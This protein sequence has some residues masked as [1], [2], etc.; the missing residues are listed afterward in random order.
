[1]NYVQKFPVAICGVALGF[2]ALGNL[3]QTSYKGLYLACGIISIFLLAIYTLKFIVS[4]KVVLREL[5]DPIG[6][7]VAATFPMAVMLISVYMKADIG[8]A[9]QLFWFVGIALHILCIALFTS[10][11]VT[12]F[13]WENVHASWFVARLYLC[14]SNKSLYCRIYSIYYAKVCT[15]SFGYAGN[16]FNYLCGFFCVVHQVSYKT[17]LSQPCR[18]YFSFCN[19]C[20]CTYA[21]VGIP[22]R[23]RPASPMARWN[24][25]C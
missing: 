25:H 10:R 6:L 21:D 15:V 11:Y 3:F 8:D 22:G 7:S 24:R 23:T 13:N 18:I 1:M 20:Y 14:S 12:E 19:L 4:T 17:V 16:R 2:A 9:A 5:S